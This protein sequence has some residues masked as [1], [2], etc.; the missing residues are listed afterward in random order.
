MSLVNDRSKTP[1]SVD[2]WFRKGIPSLEA[3]KRGSAACWPHYRY[4]PDG[5]HTGGLEDTWPG[6]YVIFCFPEGR[7]E[8]FRKL[9]KNKGKQA[10]GTSPEPEEDFDGISDDNE[11][12]GPS[13]DDPPPRLGYMEPVPSQDSGAKAT[14]E[15]EAKER[16]LANLHMPYSKK[17]LKP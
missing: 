11:Q 17:W 15:R 12:A 16:E 9:D 6:K 10:A 14:A 2:W 4:L 5:L 7:E 3:G 8:Y 13:N 1:A